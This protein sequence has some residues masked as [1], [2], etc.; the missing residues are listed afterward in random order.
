MTKFKPDDRV[1]RLRHLDQVPRG[2]DDGP[3]RR[4]SVVRVVWERV[5]AAGRPLHASRGPARRKAVPRYE[6]RWDDRHE[7]RRSPPRLYRGDELQPEGP[8]T[9]RESNAIVRDVHNL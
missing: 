7:D 2:D 8:L 4:G 3:H 9:K 5:D 6:V 1:Q